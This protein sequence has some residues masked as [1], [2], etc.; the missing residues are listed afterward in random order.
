MAPLRGHGVRGCEEAGATEPSRRIVRRAIS[1]VVYFAHTVDLWTPRCQSDG[2]C[3]WPS[4]P[5]PQALSLLPR[6]MPT[7]PGTSQRRV[8]PRPLEAASASLLRPSVSAALEA[9]P[10]PWGN[11]PGLL[12]QTSS[13]HYAPFSVLSLPSCLSQVKCIASTSL[14]HGFIRTCNTVRGIVLCLPDWGRAVCVCVCVC[15]FSR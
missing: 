10:C 7:L 1:G 9:R 13:R 8:L 4:V 15:V 6:G 14:S 5:P 11:L 3:G 12:I 2:R